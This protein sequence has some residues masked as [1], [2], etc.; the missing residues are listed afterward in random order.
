T[1]RERHAV[2][3]AGPGD[4]AAA[5]RFYHRRAE[6]AA[7]SMARDERR[8]ANLCSDPQLRVLVHGARELGGYAVTTET[9]DA[10]GGRVLKV[11]DMAAGSPES[12][13]ALLGHLSQFSGESV[14]WLASATDLA[15]SGL[16]R[17]P[18][19]LREGYKPRGIATV[20]PMFQFRVVDVEEAL[21]A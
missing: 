18:A 11:L 21:R 4:C 20:R 1:Y 7:C 15:A 19:P 14:E 16:L 10:Y 9:R 12:W 6:G 17:S 5:A 13:R 3:P 8:W 2:R